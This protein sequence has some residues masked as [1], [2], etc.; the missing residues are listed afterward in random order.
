MRL[1]NLIPLLFFGLALMF[2]SAGK[3]QEQAS[4]DSG[5]RIVRKVVPNYPELA[6]R[7]NLGGTVRILATVAPDGSVRS[8][9]AKG[10]SP[11]LIQAAED[12]LYRWKFASATVETKEVI[13]LHFNPQQ[14]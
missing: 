14:Q 10:G 6:R 2:A 12:S 5:R 1:R 13:E 3:A 4:S 11:V 8:V 9:E 7:M